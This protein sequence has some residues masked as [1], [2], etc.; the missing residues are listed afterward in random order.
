MNVV[1][2]PQST[3]HFNTA[4]DEFPP[5]V[6][7]QEC[8]CASFAVQPAERLDDLTRTDPAVDLDR[9]P[10]L[11]ELVG[12]RQAFDLAAIGTGVE[13]E[14]DGPGMLGFVRRVGSRPSKNRIRR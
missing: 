12:D 6:A 13:H 11:C 5:D 14:V 1:R 8:R 4:R 9:Q 10:H 3:I 7:A 2:I